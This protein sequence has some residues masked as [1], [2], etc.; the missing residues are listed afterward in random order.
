LLIVGSGPLKD[1]LLNQARTLAIDE[2]FELREGVTHARVPDYMKRMSVLVL[3]SVTTP[4]W[5]EQF[6]HV[7]VE[8]MASGLP[9]IGSDSG[10]IPEVIGDAG[11]IVREG[12]VEQLAAALEKLLSDEPLQNRLSELGY[13]RIRQNYSDEV[14]ASRLASFFDTVL[15][16]DR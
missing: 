5:K 14:I 13:K 4:F 9:V 10:A 11:V 6:G 1:D 8:A 3:P 16:R 7:L 15:E 12:D 2:R